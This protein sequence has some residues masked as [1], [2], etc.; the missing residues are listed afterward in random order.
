MRTDLQRAGPVLLA[1]AALGALSLVALDRQR[2]AP[3]DAG[4]P[5]APAAS[6]AAAAPGDTAGRGAVMTRT[7]V[8]RPGDTLGAIAAQHATTVGALMAANDIADADAIF[9][10]QELR[11]QVL[12][13]GEGPAL[14]TVPDGELVHG[15]AYVGFDVAAVVARHGGPLAGYVE[16]VNGS[17]LSGAEIVRRVARDFSVGPRV[18]LAFLEA[19]SGYVTGVAPA[20][21][22]A[23]Q[24]P[25][26]LEDPARAGL[27]LQLNWLADRLNGGYYDWRG[28]D[29]RILTLRDGTVWA[30]HPT[31]DAGSFAV[32]RALG[33]QSGPAELPERIA[34]FDA[35]YRR[36]FG[37]PE[38]HRPAVP[39]GAA[40]AFPLLALPWARG[41][42]WWFTGGPHGGWAEGSGWA[43]LDF[44]PDGD[45]LGCAVA[46]AWV[47]AV[48][49]GL[50]IEA[51]EGALYLDL[52]ADGHRQTGPGV[53][54]LHLAELGR[55]RPGTRV[56]R[57]DRLGH[58][59]CEGGQSTATHLHIARLRDGEWLPAAGDDPFVM[60]G[61]RATGAPKA[62]DGGLAH[63]DGRRREACECRRE[64]TN[65]V[66]W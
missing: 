54:Y 5:A 65:D 24:Y 23:P 27:W 60:G 2:A 40:A 41:E 55:A 25:A 37:P 58:P 43:A 34:A 45:P 33:L 10:G 19:R 17:T 20:G 49:D 59:S 31:L 44:V 4:V 52:D 63:D 30:G 39:S 53:F 26:G 16:T 32:Q 11:L 14:R 62:Y 38:A 36:L 42:L 28:R 1:A 15:P 35:A 64:G 12:P 6:G 51:G 8:V 21:A 50:L 46:A 18:L 57:G 22:A 3:G 9:V 29:N 7:Y 56:A 61:W 47:T 48:A 66:S 13:S